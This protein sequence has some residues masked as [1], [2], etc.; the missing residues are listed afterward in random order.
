MKLMIQLNFGLLGNFY[1]ATTQ[2]LDFTEHYK[3]LGYE[4]HLIFASTCGGKNGYGI[5]DIKFE[6]IYDLESF[7]IFD[8]IETIPVSITDKNY[9]EYICH[10]SDNPG[11]QFWDVFFDHKVE[12]LYKTSFQHHD[13]RGFQR[14]VDLPTNLPKFNP[15]V[16]DKVEKFK[17]QNPEINSTIQLRLYGFGDRENHNEKLRQMYSYLYKSVSESKRKFYLTSSCVSCL[18]DIVNLPNVFLFGD[19]KTD[20][21]LGD[22]NFYEIEGGRE[23]QMDVLHNYIAE[24]VMIENT[25][26][27]FYYSVHWPSTFMYYAFVHNLNIKISPVGVID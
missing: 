1:I 15:I 21:N 2:L 27:V 16:Y 11:L 20:K 8:S 3:K 22:V 6:E 13:S 17:V 18:G 26:D 4:C 9:K 24:M 12:E 5:F 25:D 14:G 19:R 23:K 7:N 10:S